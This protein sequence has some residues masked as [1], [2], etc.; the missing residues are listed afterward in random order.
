[1][2]GLTAVRSV[3]GITCANEGSR[4]TGGGPMCQLCQQL[5]LDLHTFGTVAP[6]FTSESSTVTWSPL[7][8]EPAADA[9]S[10]GTDSVPGSTGTSFYAVEQQLR[11]GLHQRVRRPGQVRSYARRRADLHLRA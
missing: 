5:G 3:A 1:M 8:G 6:D 11:S 10:P 7:P 9:E 4:Q 2:S